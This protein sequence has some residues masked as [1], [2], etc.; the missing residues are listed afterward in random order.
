[1]VRY[2]EQVYRLLRVEAAASPAAEAEIAA[3]EAKHGFRL[4][5]AVREWY[6]HADADTLLTGRLGGFLPRTEVLAGFAVGAASARRVAAYYRWGSEP[7]SVVCVPVDGPDD[8]P[9]VA[10]H[11]NAYHRPTVFSLDVAAH[12]WARVV[13]DPVVARVFVGTVPVATSPLGIGPPHLDWLMEAFD[14]LPK[15]PPPA[16]DWHQFCFFGPRGRVELNCVGDPATGVRPAF[17]TLL[18]DGP[19]AAAVL[20]AEAWPFHTGPVS[21]SGILG[22]ENRARAH[23]EIFARLPGATIA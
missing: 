16:P 2:Y 10:P 9:T 12:A 22:G 21:V 18:T 7:A 1:M 20:L 4:P 13:S 6:S 5:A 15:R 17:A 23:A 11:P 19:T 3:V 8:P 14:L